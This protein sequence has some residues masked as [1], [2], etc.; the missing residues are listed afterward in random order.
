VGTALGAS[1]TRQCGGAGDD[2][3]DDEMMR[4]MEGHQGIVPEGDGDGGGVLL[5]PIP[6]Q[7]SHGWAGN[8]DG[9]RADWGLQRVRS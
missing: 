8:K 4:L 2:D 5:P 6:G 3:N 1:K 9:R 7:D